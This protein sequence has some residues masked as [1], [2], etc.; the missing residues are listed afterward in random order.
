L[1]DFSYFTGISKNH[2]KITD[3]VAPNPLH[4]QKLS[5]IS[6]MFKCT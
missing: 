2:E 4:V 3:V 6:G 1:R 5:K